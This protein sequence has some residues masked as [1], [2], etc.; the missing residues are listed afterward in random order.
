MKVVFFLFLFEIATFLFGTSD[1]FAKDTDALV[2]ATKEPERFAFIVGNTHYQRSDSNLNDLLDA[3]DEAVKFRKTLLGMG[4]KADHLYPLVMPITP[5]QTDDDAVVAAVCDKTSHE[6]QGRLTAFINLILLN[7]NNPY[8]VVYFAGHGAQSNDEFYAFGVDA[9]VDLEKEVWLVRNYTNYEVF[10][11]PT[12]PGAEGPTAVNLTKLAAVVNG[13]KGKALLM[14]IDACRDDPVLDHFVT[15]RVDPAPMEPDAKRRLSI[16]YIASRPDKYDALYRN[17]VVMF[18]GRPGQ[19]VLSGTALTSNWFSQ[20]LSQYM[21][22]A[23]HLRAPTL[24]FVGDFQY[25]AKVAQG[26]LP[27]TARQIPQHIGTMASSPFFCFLGCPQALSLWTNEKVEIISE[28]TASSLKRATT[29]YDNFYHVSSMHL[30]FVRVSN[31]VQVT[32]STS[33]ALHNPVTE[34]IVETKASPAQVAPL[35]QPINLDVFYCAG[36]LLEARRK[37]AARNFAEST[38]RTAPRD[39]VLANTYIDQ[40]RLRSLDINVN[41][42]MANPKTG[43]S[44]VLVKSNSASPAWTS[45]LRVG[46]D[47]T[48]QDNVTEGYFRA[49][50]CTGFS[51]SQRPRPLVYTQV[52]NQSQVPRAKQYLN[53]LSTNLPNLK[54]EQGIEPVQD[55]HP[56]T[57]HTPTQTEIRCYSTDQCHQAADLA[58]QLRAQVVHPVNVIRRRNS[59]PETRANPVIELWFGQEEMANWVPNQTR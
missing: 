50:F 58:T 42:A 49:Y 2:V 57:N 35:P 18:A 32:H 48:Y 15:A 19:P 27:E 1:V 52:A 34:L 7:E 20:H 28:V 21:K 3:C 54:F 13:P 9:D 4:W 44:L 56:G 45:M 40:I 46:F 6:L 59:N 29:L 39:F 31:P 23:D 43:T 41:L 53:L 26:G 55:T 47:R 25:S 11:R 22:D 51:S 30:E 12:K 37:E 33:I 17:I 36:D 10:S 14:I 38:R 16:G 5:G 8:G 24:T